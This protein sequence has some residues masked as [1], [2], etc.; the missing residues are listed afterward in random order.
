M[1]DLPTNAKLRTIIRTLM[2]MPENAVRPSNQNAPIFKGEE[3]ITVQIISEVGQGLDDSSWEDVDQ[4]HAIEH[5]DGLRITS[6]NIQY[7]NG[8]AFDQLRLLT[9]RLQSA[10]GTGYL[11]DAGFGYIT[12]ASLNDITG[13]FPDEEW[14]TRA[15]MRF[16]FYT[17]HNDS[18]L[19]PLIVQFPL[20]LYA[21]D[22]Q[23]RTSEVK[24]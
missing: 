2:A 18:V 20:S 19:T 8:N 24:P 9:D 5:L 7:Y 11:S 13:L 4:L 23:T 21:E 14:Q 6:A 12:V 3:Y 17:E 22:G 16:D 15:T 1:S 10:L